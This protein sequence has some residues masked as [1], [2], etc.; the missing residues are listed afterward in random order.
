[1][2]LKSFILTVLPALIASQACMNMDDET[3]RFTLD[4]DEVQD[5]SWLTWRNDDKRIEKYCDRG[6]VKGGHV[7]SR[8][9]E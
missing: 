9:E 3:F 8:L 2:Y 5:C 1:M 6:D 7:S 4:N